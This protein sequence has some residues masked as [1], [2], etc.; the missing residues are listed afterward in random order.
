MCHYE[1]IDTVW[2]QHHKH[3]ITLYRNKNWIN[4]FTFSVDSNKILTQIPSLI[5]NKIFNNIYDTS[6]T[7]YFILAM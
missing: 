7:G 3:G 5:K 4:L 2:F 1:K 6:G